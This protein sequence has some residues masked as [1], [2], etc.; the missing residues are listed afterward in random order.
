MRWFSHAPEQ[1]RLPRFRTNIHTV[2]SLVCDR[3]IVSFRA[4]CETSSQGGIGARG[5]GLESLLSAIW[6]HWN[7][8]FHSRH[9]PYRPIAWCVTFR[10]GAGPAAAVCN[11]FPLQTASAC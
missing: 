11:S 6:S 3:D 10:A 8:T 5:Q 4:R 2:A 1:R 7:S 9:I